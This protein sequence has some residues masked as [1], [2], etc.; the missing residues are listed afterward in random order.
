MLSLSIVGWGQDF[1]ALLVW[2]RGMA[3]TCWTAPSKLRGTNQF[4]E[5]WLREELPFGKRWQTISWRYVMDVVSPSGG[6]LPRV[7][8]IREHWAVLDQVRFT[9]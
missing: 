5:Q 8:G 7:M 6:E 9:F 4:L 3:E 2:T 1:L